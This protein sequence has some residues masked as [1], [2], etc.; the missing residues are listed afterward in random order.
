MLYLHRGNLTYVHVSLAEAAPYARHS[1]EEGEEVE[2]GEDSSPLVVARVQVDCHQYLSEEE[3]ELEKRGQHQ[4][5]EVVEMLTVL[6]AN[7]RRKG[8][9]EKRERER[10]E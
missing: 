1:V 3:R 6:P 5:L 7:G 10:R 8:E 9:R 4:G 2:G